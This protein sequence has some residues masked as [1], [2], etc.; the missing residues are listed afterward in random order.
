MD[1]VASFAK[2]DQTAIRRRR[3]GFFTASSHCGG[4]GAACEDRFQQE[5]G[6]KAHQKPPPEVL[7][8]LGIGGREALIRGSRFVLRFGG[9]RELQTILRE[10]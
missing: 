8:L 2:A 10:L 4:A 9:R 3:Q 6:Q 7:A 5:N 1:E